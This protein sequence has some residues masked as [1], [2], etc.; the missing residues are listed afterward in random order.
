MPDADLT[1]TRAIT[2]RTPPM[3]SGHGSRSSARGAAGFTATTSLKNVTGRDIHSADRIVSEWQAV[4]VRDEVRLHPEVGLSVAVAEPG[5]ALVLR[6][7]VPIGQTPAPYDFTW[8][9]VLRGQADGTTRLVV[10]ERYSYARPW[11]RLLIE[12][13]E[14]ISFVMSRRMLREIKQ[15]AEHAIVGTS[16][17]GA[18]EE[19]TVRR[20]VNARG[21]EPASASP[22]PGRMSTELQGIKLGR[23]RRDESSL[24]P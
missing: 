21:R 19:A 13:T 7:G 5:H 15:R 22:R 4:D 6:G 2:V 17:S 11:A 24:R 10:R 1:A 8:A 20:R 12:P 14:F 3:V 9:F 16:T 23:L 18:G